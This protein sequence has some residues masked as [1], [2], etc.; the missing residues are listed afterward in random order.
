MANRQT[1][2]G[3]TTKAERKEQARRERVEIERRIARS[4]RNRRLALVVVLAIAVGVAT[5][6]LTRP[7][8]AIATPGDLF[9]V[10]ADAKQAAGCGAV[11]DVGPYQPEDQDRVHISGQMPPLSTY[12]SVPPAS[13]PHNAVTQ[14]PGVY[15]APPDIDRVVHSLEHGAAVIWYAPDASGAELERL[16]TFFDQSTAG[17]RVIVAPYDYP[18]QG[19]A[20]S[21]P[22]G[23]EMALVSWHHV[24]TCGQ[25]SLAAAFDFA[26]KYGA[27]PY[28]RRTY[29]G[30]APEAGLAF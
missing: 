23:T 10:A 25:V 13:G 2:N 30:D 19:A 17:A 12:P 4:K 11:E 15:D 27:P 14:G 9:R 21:L 18:A 28:G 20:G 8:T 26:A 3:R 5:F 1:T 22:S 29:L 7:S 16:R 6:A 24:Q